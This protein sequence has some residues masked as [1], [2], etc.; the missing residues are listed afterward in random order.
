MASFIGYML[1][2]SHSSFYWEIDEP[3]KLRWGNKR[4]L[5]IPSGCAAKRYII[6]KSCD[7]RGALTMGASARSP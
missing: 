7:V 2:K 6:Y 3:Q 4:L 1:P 5:R